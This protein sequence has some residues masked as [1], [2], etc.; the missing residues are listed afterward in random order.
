MVVSN[1]RFVIAPAYRDALSHQ[2]LFSCAPDNVDP[3]H[4]ALVPSEP[5][6]GPA[7]GRDD[8]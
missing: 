8:R 6:H 5:A 1:V 4:Y 2:L 7:K 3:A